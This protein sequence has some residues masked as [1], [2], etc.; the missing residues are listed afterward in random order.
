[1][2]V[3]YPILN[4]IHRVMNNGGKLGEITQLMEKIGTWAKATSERIISAHSLD[5]WHK[6]QWLLDLG[7]ELLNVFDAFGVDGLRH[8][9]ENGTSFKF[10]TVFDTEGQPVFTVYGSEFFTENGN[11]YNRISEIPTGEV[12][13]YWYDDVPRGWFIKL[14][15]PRTGV[16]TVV[17]CDDVMPKID[18]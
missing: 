17:P 6:E 18:D 7:E 15:H 9:K 12:A 10:G 8:R 3:Y 13:C 1:M 4:D 11:K 2:A 14:P 16:I 5:S